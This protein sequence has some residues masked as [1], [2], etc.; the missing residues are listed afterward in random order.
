MNINPLVYIIILNFNS[1]DETINCLKS[2]SKIT[3]NNYKI[4]VVDN[5]SCDNSIEKLE[6][7]KDIKL[8]KS[9]KN[10]G[11]ANGNNLGIRYALDSGADYIC[12]LNNDV[13]V[14]K[15]FLEPLI[16]YLTEHID[17]GGVGPCILDYKHKDIVQALGGTIDFYRGL[18]LGRCK[19]KNI[20]EIYESITDVD[21]L[22]GACFVC[23]SEV[24]DRLGLI[25]ENYF[26]FYEETEFCVKMKKIG[27]KLFCIKESKVYH[28]GSAT[29]SKFG[30]LS[31]YFL[32]RNRIIFMR[33]NANIFQKIVFPVYL[34]AETVG[35]ILI[36]H[37]S[38]KLFKYYFEGYISDK[39][40][41]DFEKVNY[42]IDKSSYKR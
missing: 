34:I 40:N 31:Y 14:D 36:R 6:A 2:L 32:N 25:P 27:Y 26:L 38:I 15:R 4:V 5:A 19:G 41:V 20:N 11:Y 3:Y 39:N 33:R 10:F 9:T 13:E 42:Y 8:I 35:R 30:G 37:E 29:I 12:V 16:D 23:R 22:G 18:A 7:I 1:I 17:V 28:K 21:Y 24:F